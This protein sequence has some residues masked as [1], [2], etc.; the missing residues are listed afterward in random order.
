MLHALHRIVVT[1]N[2]L[3][4]A[5]SPTR[6]GE[7]AN[8]TSLD[9]RMDGMDNV[10]PAG[11][12]FFRV[13]RSGGGGGDPRSS[14]DESLLETPTY[15]IVLV[16]L[17]FQAVSILFTVVVKSIQHVLRSRRRLGLLEAVNHSVHELT[18]LGFVSII[19]LTLEQPISD[20]CVDVA[21]FRADWTVLQFVYGEGYCPC[22]LESTSNVQKCVLEYASCGDLSGEGDEFCNCDAAD[23]TCVYPKKDTAVPL[24]EQACDGPVALD[25]Q[26]RCGEGKVRAVSILALEQ[27]HY[28]I[29][30]L[31]I[32]H[33]LCGFVLYGLAW[34]RVKWEWGRWEKQHDVHH[35][36]VSEVLNV[37]YNDL[38]KSLQLQSMGRP[39]GHGRSKSEGEG[40]KEKDPSLMSCPS[41][42]GEVDL[43]EDAD[44]EADGSGAGRAG[45]DGTASSQRQERTT[46]RVTVAFV[47]DGGIDHDAM[48]EQRPNLERRS[49][50]LPKVLGQEDGP[51]PGLGLRRSLRRARSFHNLAVMERKFR[52]SVLS[53][54]NQ[55]SRGAWRLTKDKSHSL[56]QG[57]GPLLVS[58]SQYY[59]L[60]ASF[61]YTHKLG[62]TFNFLSHVMASMVRARTHSSVDSYDL[63]PPLSLLV[64]RACPFARR[65]TLP[66]WLASRP[67]SGSSP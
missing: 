13:P 56:L 64:L 4:P 61:V 60:R 48:I 59:K 12:S 15:S 62:G 1:S 9:R 39:V 21:Y 37:Y 17:A 30:L 42:I 47:D 6:P 40:F 23:P 43:D 54:M 22:C 7:K 10:G 51:Q 57:A 5:S 52:L 36:K 18:L 44:E 67:Y 49:A 27:V 55:W 24:E 46:R 33:V 26:D 34:L 50:T 66:I 19:L 65:K 31:S 11:Q 45:E 16:L 3:Y 29:F 32:V 28:M 63:P 25:G 41:R 58:Q 8:Q 53:H 20:I 14:S 38:E 2:A 35:E